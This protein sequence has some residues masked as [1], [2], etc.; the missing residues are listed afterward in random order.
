MADRRSSVAYRIAFTYSAAFALAMLLLGAAV[1]LA[2]DAAFRGQ[3][4]RTVI[5]ESTSLARETDPTEIASDIA[6]R[7]RPGVHDAFLYALYDPNGRRIAGT[8]DAPRPEPGL[9]TISFR[10]AREGHDIARANTVAVRDGHR[11]TVALD[12]ETIEEIDA[13]ILTLFAS[14]FVLILLAAV[15]GALILG[16]YLRT[17]LGVISG[18]ARA[19]VAGDLTRRVPIGPRNDEFDQAG[20]ALN[21]MLD[22]IAQLMENLRQV[23]SDVAHDLRTPLLRLRNRLDPVGSDPAATEKAI[24]Q[25]DQLLALFGSILRIAE[26]EGGALARTFVQID[27]SALASQVCEDY[28]PALSDSGR[29]F[30]CAIA[31]GIWVAGDRELLVQAMGNL[32]DN[33]R[34]H[35][36]A[37]TH[38]TLVLDVQAERGRLMVCDDGPG[39]DAA[40][41][42]RILQRFVRTEASRTTPGN[43]LGL[44]LVAA[45]AAAHG[46]EVTVSDNHP[47]LRVAINLPRL[48]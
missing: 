23:S 24:E 35:T 27:L 22:R 12:T 5:E 34:V 11:L 7:E 40:D 8:L 26:I 38:V 16:S 6:E 33:A 4:D 30:D 28:Q 20:T 15:A 47:G 18:T 19:V 25:A 9:T 2:A 39:V 21:V 10:D 46:G 17:R 36:P 41:R 44:N 29:S 37:G 14:A 1:Y 32:L 45:V 42:E 48:S 3:R 31:A 43:G 13:T